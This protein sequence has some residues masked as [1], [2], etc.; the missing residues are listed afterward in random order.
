MIPSFFAME[1]KFS[2]PNNAGAK[3][4]SK[5]FRLNALINIRV[6]YIFQEKRPLIVEIRPRRLAGIR[7][8]TFPLLYLGC[9]I[10]Y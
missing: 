9:T 6:A 2:D 8:R 1:K 3:R 5:Y 10:F 7:R 4:V